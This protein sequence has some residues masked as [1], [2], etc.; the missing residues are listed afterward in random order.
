M[1]LLLHDDGAGGDPIA[2]GDIADP[3]L[4]EIA[5]TQLAVYGQIE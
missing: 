2:V 5:A 4:H 1:G 3:K